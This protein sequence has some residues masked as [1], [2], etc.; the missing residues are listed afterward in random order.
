[1]SNANHHMELMAPY[2]PEDGDASKTAITTS[3]QKLGPF[4]ASRAYRISGD[5][6]FHYVASDVSGV[7]CDTTDQVHRTNWFPLE[8][9]IRPGKE[10][11]NIRSA[12]SSGNLWIGPMPPGIT[13]SD[14][15]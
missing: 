4:V 6:D 2:P 3:S 8:I 14:Q 5:V 1:M 11:L 7:T 9:T 15:E 12:T 13:L 10:Y